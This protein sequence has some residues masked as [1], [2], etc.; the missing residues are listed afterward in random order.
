LPIFPVQIRLI[1]SRLA[2]FLAQGTRRGAPPIPHPLAKSRQFNAL[3]FP[4]LLSNS[5]G[6]LQYLWSDRLE[7]PGRRALARRQ[8]LSGALNRFFEG[9]RWRFITLMLLVGPIRC[10]LRGRCRGSIERR[11]SIPL[12]FTRSRLCGFLVRFLR[13]LRSTRL[14]LHK[15]S[16]L[17]LYGARR[18]TPGII[19]DLADGSLYIG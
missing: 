12:R 4:L 1:L 15:T 17:P 11:R 2:C 10:W 16:S 6:G 8:D 3:A 14:F 5:L 13:D 18:H 7:R 19:T 9:R